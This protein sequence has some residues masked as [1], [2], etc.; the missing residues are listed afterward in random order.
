MPPL[1]MMMETENEADPA[2]A[3]G[4]VLVPDPFRR[5]RTGDLREQG[6][7]QGGQATGGRCQNQ[8]PQEVQTRHLSGQGGG[9]QRQSPRRSRQEKLHAEVRARGVEARQR[10]AT[11]PHGS[12]GNTF[13]QS[14]FMST[15]VQ[16]RLSAS[17][18]A[19]S[20]RPTGELRS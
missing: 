4:L 14:R 3:R 6:R 13:F 11:R 1:T 5:I 18:Q 19:L 20:S 16:P 17:S 9:Q 12:H 2:P 10:S 8:L 15:T 7:Q